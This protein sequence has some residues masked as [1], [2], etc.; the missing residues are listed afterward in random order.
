MHSA[1]SLFGDKFDEDAVK[2][3]RRIERLA[4]KECLTSGY[5]KL[6]RIGQL[7]G[8]EAEKTNATS[9]DLCLYVFQA[10]EFSLR[11]ECMKAA[12]VTSDRIETNILVIL[13]RRQTHLVA[14]DLVKYLE[15][16]KT[17][18]NLAKDEL[19]KIMDVFAV[20]DVFQT[21][22]A[23]TQD[24]ADLVENFKSNFKSGI[25][26]LLIDFLYDVM[27]GIYDKKYQAALAA[28]QG[29]S[30]SS[31]DLDLLK[32]GGFESYRELYRLITLAHSS[33]DLG[34]DG[35]PETSSRQLRRYA[36]EEAG[37]DPADAEQSK[38][39]AE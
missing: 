12:D 1:I 35:A 22:F 13:S 32:A 11:G 21:T 23:K 6:A 17:G 36:S 18:A 31:F 9:A 38:K 37:D 16:T 14:T 5:A 30:T 29:K 39:A 34:V 15:P 24:D 28:P 8:K 20:Y 7:C 10:I 19:F 33:V 2:C 25:S 26:H 27:S 3:I 4:G